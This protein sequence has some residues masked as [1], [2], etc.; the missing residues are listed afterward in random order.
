MRVDG[1][2][3]G[4]AALAVA[5]VAGCAHAGTVTLRAQDLLRRDV[6]VRDITPQWVRPVRRAYGRAVRLGSIVAA[7]DA[8]RSARAAAKLDSIQLAEARALYREPYRI[9]AQKLA[10]AKATAGE[11]SARLESMV[12]VLRDR[13]GNRFAAKL[14]HDRRLLARIG[15]GEVS[16]IDA[17]LPYP[18]LRRPPR[19]ATASVD[20][21][22]DVP[23]RRVALSLFGIGGRVPAGMIGQ[24]LYYLGPA[25]QSGTMLRVS[26]RLD[27]RPARTLKLPVSALIFDG[28]EAIAFR[29]IA[30]HRFRSFRL[31]H[32]L[33]YYS[34]GHLAGYQSAWPGHDRVPIAVE[35]AG[36]LW[37]LLER[38]VGK[39]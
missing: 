19:S 30:A 7:V 11:A 16:V 22:P 31:S 28:R 8:I 9:S 29:R 36:L 20:G 38:A 14:L 17:I 25:L 3:M 37:A 2:F 39:R 12:G 6:I 26:L 1:T 4:A 24:S 18:V 34:H 15:G 32:A 5:A 27:T 13:Y 10:Q 33:P 35:G 21:G 23:A